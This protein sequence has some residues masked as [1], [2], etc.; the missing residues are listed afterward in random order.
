MTDDEPVVL[1]A[2]CQLELPLPK[3]EFNERHLNRT[4]N[5]R[6]FRAKAEKIPKGIAYPGARDAINE[7]EIEY[8]KGNTDGEN[9]YGHLETAFK[10]VVEAIQCWVNPMSHGNVL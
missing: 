2:R 4:R 1:D 6:R 5:D 10:R 3:K 9:E 7:I 8:R